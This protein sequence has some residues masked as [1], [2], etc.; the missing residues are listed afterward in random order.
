PTRGARVVGPGP[1]WPSGRAHGGRPPVV[2]GPKRR[3]LGERGEAGRGSSLGRFG[4]GHRPRR[5]SPRPPA[6]VGPDPAPLARPP[7]GPGDRPAARAA[8][9]QPPAPRL[10]A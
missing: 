1:G 8:V 4:A 3:S 7:A 5:G 10:A 6:R 2:D 9:A